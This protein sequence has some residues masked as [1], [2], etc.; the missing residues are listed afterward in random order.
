M[1]RQRTT[2]CLGKESRSVTAFVIDG[3]SMRLSR[4]P[5]QL[6]LR[7]EEARVVAQAW[8]RVMA[9]PDRVDV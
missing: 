8:C 1:H 5:G 2:I 6:T 9:P 3:E 4:I 7:A